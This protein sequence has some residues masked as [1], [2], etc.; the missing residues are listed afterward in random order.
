M[1]SDDAYRSQRAATITALRY[2]LPTIADVAGIEEEEGPGFWRVAVTPLTPGAC[3]FEFMLHETKRY[4][5]A[6]GGRVFEDEPVTSLESFPHLLAAIAD[7]RIDVEHETSALTGATVAMTTAIRPHDR[8]VWLR[9]EIM[10]AT[11]DAPGETVTRTRRYL[12]YR[13]R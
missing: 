4:A 11:A 1:L 2:W 9:R 8:P 3:P 5:L 13:R 7:G 12:P 6:V 10:T